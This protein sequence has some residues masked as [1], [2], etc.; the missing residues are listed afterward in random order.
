MAEDSH[1]IEAD[2][3]PAGDYAFDVLCDAG[4]VTKQQHEILREATQ[5]TIAK[6][7]AAFSDVDELVEQFLSGQIQLDDLTRLLQDAEFHSPATSLSAETQD[8]EELR[9]AGIFRQTSGG[10]LAFREPFWTSLYRLPKLFG[11]ASD[12]GILS[13][14]SGTAM[15]LWDDGGQSGYMPD[16]SDMARQAALHVGQEPV[17]VFSNTPCIV[18]PFEFAEM[19][20]PTPDIVRHP[21]FHFMESVRTSTE[22]VLYFW[23]E[24]KLTARIR[25]HIGRH[26]DTGWLKRQYVE[27]LEPYL[28]NENLRVFIG[29]I[30]SLTRMDWSVPIVTPRA[31]IVG[32]RRAGDEWTCISV[33][34]RRLRRSIEMLVSLVAAGTVALDVNNLLPTMLKFLG[35]LSTVPAW[36]ASRAVGPTEPDEMVTRFETAGIPNSA[37]EGAEWI[38]DHLFRAAAALP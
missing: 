24:E 13:C 16:K 30:S 10:T 34:R 22:P 35:A 31:A 9:R 32:P 15:H 5:Q 37:P 19:R 17:V 28:G 36:T 7:R 20:V 11:I 1:P 29:D 33:S 21:M 8:S 27:W 14:L 18:N 25:E 26:G 3:R 4:V 38:V 12:R 6:R 23:N 2:A